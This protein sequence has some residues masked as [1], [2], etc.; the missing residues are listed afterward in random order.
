MKKVVL[1]S[2]ITLLTVFPLLTPAQITQ[3]P[4]TP[5]T[6]ERIIGILDRFIS[7][8][9]AILL[10][11]AVIFIIMAAFKYLTAAG[12]M[13]KIKSAHSMLIYA[14]VALGVGLISRGLVFLVRQLLG[15][16]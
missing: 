14:M 12:D 3:P 4:E 9:F 16:S 7:W 15:I 6:I 8:L 5:V 1:L 10:A 2:A 13:E 11:L